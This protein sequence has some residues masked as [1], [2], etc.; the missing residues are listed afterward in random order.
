MI[1]NLKI[2]QIYDF[3]LNKQLLRALAATD[4]REESPLGEL[5]AAFD[6]LQPEVVYSGCGA[7][8][9]LQ[10]SHRMDSQDVE[11]PMGLRPIEYNE[12]DPADVH[13]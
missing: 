7:L 6:L 3:F 13:G 12:Y 5:P 8:V 2:S 1:C 10:E 9:R 4:E 11:H